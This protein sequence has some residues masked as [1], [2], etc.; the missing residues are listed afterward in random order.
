MFFTD[1]GKVVKEKDNFGDEHISLESTQMINE[2]LITSF[3]TEDE[4]LALLESHS[5]ITDLINSDVVTEKTLVRLDKK[6]RIN[7]VQKVAVF[8]I[9]KEK[10]DPIFKKLMTVWRIERN[11]EKKLFDKYGNEGLRRAKKTVQKNYRQ[12]GQAFIKINDRSAK[13]I[14]KAVSGKGRKSTLAPKSR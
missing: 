10:N 5:E 3:L 11:L 12:K 8:T 4:Q 14:T 2:A 1:A 7:Q 9:A 6:A 13:A